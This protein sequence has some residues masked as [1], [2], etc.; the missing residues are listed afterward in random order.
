MKKKKAY[1]LSSEAP[2]GSNA[3][4]VQDEPRKQSAGIHHS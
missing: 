3:G 4:Q 2:E 1:E